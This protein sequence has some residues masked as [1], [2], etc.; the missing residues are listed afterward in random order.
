MLC[1]VIV[2]LLAHKH[3]S[4][5]NNPGFKFTY[6]F[7]K[8]IYFRLN[9]FKQLMIIF[10]S[11]QNHLLPIKCCAGIERT[12]QPTAWQALLRFILLGR[13]V[14]SLDALCQLLL[15]ASQRW[16]ALMT[17]IAYSCTKLTLQWILSVTEFSDI[18]EA[19]LKF[20]ASVNFYM[21]HGGTNWGFMNGANVE[22]TL[23]YMVG[24]QPNC[25]SYGQ[26]NFQALGF[27]WS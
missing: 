26:F 4:Q 25:T 15:S 2:L 8:K 14:W 5:G 11:A 19:I 7:L 22:E 21:F 6:N 27:Q 3:S 13:M 18:T 23:P 24:Y 1:S 20:P 17:M 16:G 9:E 12:S 10:S